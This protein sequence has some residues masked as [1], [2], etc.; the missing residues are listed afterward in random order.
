MTV[1]APHTGLSFVDDRHTVW[2]ILSNI[3]GKYSCFVYIKS[4]LPTR[5]GRDAHILLFDHFLGPNNVGN[6]ASDADIKLT[7]TLYNDGN[8]KFTWETC[9]QI[10]TEQNSVLNGLKGYGYASIDYS[11]KVRHFLKG[12]KT[13]ELDVCKTQVM[14]TPYIC[15]IFA[16]TVKLYSTF[17][18]Q[19]K[20]GNP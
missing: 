1:R 10:N 3:Y 11:S 15:D 14:T 8:K 20:A 6:M 4:A 19:P 7:G 17:F 2:E 9:V 18:K 5:N 12:I 13:N 16:S